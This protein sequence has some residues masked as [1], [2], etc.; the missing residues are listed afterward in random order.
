MVKKD[1]KTCVVCGKKYT[2]C[3]SCYKHIKFPDYLAIA[4]D[5]NCYNLY[6]IISAYNM[7]LMTKEKAIEELAKCDISGV[8][9]FPE[10]IKKTINEINAVTAKEVKSVSKTVKN[11]KEVSE[12]I[13]NKQ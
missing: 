3:P 4:H 5:E 1:N 2:F 10:D 6:N 9:N 12:K 11:A 13:P 7:K 8:D